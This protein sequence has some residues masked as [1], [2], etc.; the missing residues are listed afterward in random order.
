MAATL[1]TFAAS[2]RPGD[3]PGKGCG[4]SL[5]AKRS[6]IPGTCIRKEDDMGHTSEDRM[7]CN[8]GAAT[9]QSMVSPPRMKSHFSSCRLDRIRFGTADTVQGRQH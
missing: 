8:R 5:G 9:A 6:R 2:L 7:C 4:E 1:R 3:G